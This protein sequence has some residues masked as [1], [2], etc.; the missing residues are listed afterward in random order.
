MSSELSLE[1]R[2]LNL[3]SP[4]RLPNPAFFSAVGVDAVFDP[5]EK[6]PKAPIGE[7]F[8]LCEAE[9]QGELG[10]PTAVFKGLVELR[11]REPKGEEA[12]GPLSFTFSS[13]FVLESRKS[14]LRRK[15]AGGGVEVFASSRKKRGFDPVGDMGLPIDSPVS[16]RRAPGRPA[17]GEEVL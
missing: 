4:R 12:S 3:L 17:F 6:A 5:R 9:P 15:R 11:F 13:A 14:V 7:K 16:R 1:R 10:P 2:P 8:A